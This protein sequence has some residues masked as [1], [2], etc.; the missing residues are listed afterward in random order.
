MVRCA[1]HSLFNGVKVLTFK[2]GFVQ[3][4]RVANSYAYMLWSITEIEEGQSITVQY[5]K[6]NG[7]FAGKCACASCHPDNPPVAPRRSV[8]SASG[9]GEASGDI[10]TLKRKTRR[11]GRRMRNVKLREL[12]EL[13]KALE[14]LDRAAEGLP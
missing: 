13:D 4:K 3:I 11:G 9:M 1:F 5:R 12:E 6:D 14:E 8:T 10:P 7:Y 2:I